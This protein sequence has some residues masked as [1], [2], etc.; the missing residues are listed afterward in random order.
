M[1]SACKDGEQF[2][3]IK[4]IHRHDVPLLYPDDANVGPSKMC[5]AALWASGKKE[6]WVRWSCRYL[7][8]KVDE[9]Q[10]DAE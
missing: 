5:D 10:T 3:L 2:I 7:R 1:V 6:K 8:E 4:K 9:D